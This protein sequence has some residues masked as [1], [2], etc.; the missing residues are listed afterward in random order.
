MIRNGILQRLCKFD[1][2]YET[3]S[4]DA[5][6]VTC[7]HKMI[8]CFQTKIAS[9]NLCLFATIFITLMKQCCCTFVQFQP[10]TTKMWMTLK[11]SINHNE[12]I[13]YTLIIFGWNSLQ[14]SVSIKIGNEC[15]LASLSHSYDYFRNFFWFFFLLC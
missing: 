3:D 5:Y 2:A 1:I 4:N 6:A 13:F 10:I 9:R 15:C 11:N 12:S 7:I 14:H 8:W